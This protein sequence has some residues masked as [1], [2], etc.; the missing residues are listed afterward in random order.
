MDKLPAMALD[1]SL[2]AFSIWSAFAIRLGAEQQTFAHAQLYSFRVAIP[3]FFLSLLLFG[4][5]RSFM[6]SWIAV[7]LAILVGGV[8][9]T[10]LMYF[11]WRSGWIEGFSRTVIAL[12]MVLA[13]ILIYS[14]RLLLRLRKQRPILEGRQA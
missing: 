6:P 13:F 3:V 1:L 8:V 7:G 12:D 10:G 4:V 2:L 14:S 9:F 5:Y 11:A